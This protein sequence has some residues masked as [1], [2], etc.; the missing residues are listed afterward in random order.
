MKKQIFILVLAF[1]AVTTAFGQLAP[2]PVTCLTSDA[3]HPIAGTPYTYQ[4][5]VPITPSPGTAWTAGS[6]NYLWFVTQE[7]QF[8]NAGVLTPTRETAAGTLL[9][10][11]DGNYN[12]ATSTSN[13]ISLTWKSF[14]YDPTKPIFIVINAVG[15]NGVCI[16]MNMKVFKIE[17]L[18]AFTLDIDNLTELG[19]Q[20]TPAVY[21]DVYS[22]CISPIVSAVY[23]PTGTAPGGVLYDFGQNVLL[24]EVVAANWSEAWKPSVQLTGIDAKETVK[25]EWSK[26]KTFTAGVTLMTGS[27]VGT[28]AVTADYA[29]PANVP[30][31][32]GGVVGAAGES[33]F[34]RVTLDHTNGALNYEGLADQSIKLAVDGVTVPTTGTGV[35]DVHT[36]A[37]ATLP[38]QACPWVD[39]FV[40]DFAMQTIKARP[41]I[42]AAAATPAPGLLPVRP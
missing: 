6:L 7:K 18:N 8:I 25:V 26:D 20:H 15:N 1:F 31:P 33:I 32:A 39:L 4:I 36:V 27:A 34:I 19:V 12:L 3:L 23:D 5:D 9:A 24:Y 37:G 42:T 21:G 38:A 30:A 35:G 41:T 16:P 40:N 17:P 13:S 22:Q 10:T 29:S 11:T 14:V 28:A 2:R